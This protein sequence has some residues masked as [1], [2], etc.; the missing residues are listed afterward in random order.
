MTRGR[1]D[2]VAMA[3]RANTLLLDHVEMTLS[4]T[5][6]PVVVAP[7]SETRATHATC[8]LFLVLMR[9]TRTIINSTTIIMPHITEDHPRR[10]CLL[11]LQRASRTF[12]DK[13]LRDCTTRPTIRITDT[14]SSRGI[15][16]LIIAVRP[17]SIATPLRGI[18]RQDS[19]SRVRALSTKILD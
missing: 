3:I 1:I 16:I 2:A 4:K 11:L 5:V 17:S 6:P 8:D 7:T 15:L 12:P 10:R 9:R 19:R 18:A 14:R 13:L